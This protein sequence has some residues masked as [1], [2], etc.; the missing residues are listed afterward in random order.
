[1]N[2][3][4]T[5]AEKKLARRVYDEARLAELDETLAEFKSRVAALVSTDDMWP[6]EGTFGTGAGNWTRNTTTGTLAWVGS[7]RG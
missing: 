5:D 1:M 7:L 6:L 4:W 3:K 2:W